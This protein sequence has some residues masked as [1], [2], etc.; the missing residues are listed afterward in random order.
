MLWEIFFLQ[1]CIS[2]LCSAEDGHSGIINISHSIFVY[3]PRQRFITITGKDRFFV[4]WI[5]FAT[6]KKKRPLA[7]PCQ[8]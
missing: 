1:I 5:V 3:A 6:L 8:K 4:G 7:I 2:F